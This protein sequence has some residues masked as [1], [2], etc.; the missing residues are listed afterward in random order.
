MFKALILSSIISASAF[1]CGSINPVEITPHSGI[2]PEDTSPTTTISILDVVTTTTT[3]TTTI[4]VK[5][6]SFVR[7]TPPVP[8]ASTSVDLVAATRYA[9]RTLSA[10]DVLREI[11]G[12]NRFNH[13]APKLDG[14]SGW[15][16]G[17]N[18][19]RSSAAGLGQT[20]YNVN[21][22][23]TLASHWLG[24]FTWSDVR[25]PDCLADAVLID[26]LYNSCGLGD[27]TPPY[28]CLT[29]RPR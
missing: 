13:L 16:C 10:R 3:T 11:M 27:W 14:E 28:D 25:G 15:N 23:R 6:A 22:E 20:L 26:I 4:V 12:K 24:P 19:R 5:P 9:L 1:A 8:I 17:I 7:S 29:P 2:A 21:R 18:N